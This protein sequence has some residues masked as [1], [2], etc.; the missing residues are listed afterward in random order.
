VGSTLT[1]TH[2]SWTSAT[3]VTYQ[4]Q[5]QRC[6]LVCTDIPS[7]T[8]DTYVAAADD[9]G[10]SLRV[11][12]TATNTSGSAS[13]Q[14]LNTGV[15]L[16][17]PSLSLNAA[18]V[19]AGGVLTVSGSGFA[20]DTEVAVSIHSDPVSLGSATVGPAGTFALQVTIPASFTGPHV[21]E[22]SGTSALSAP[23]VLSVDVQVDAPAATTTTAP[24]SSS[25]PGGQGGTSSG[26]S[27][28][29]SGQ[30]GS[31]GSSSQGGASLPYTGAASFPLAA[32]GLVLLA[33]GLALALWSRRLWFKGW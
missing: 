25:P 30:P 23:L 12:V 9:V 5:W 1:A 27:S 24:G 26:G 3:P 7:A 14:S 8:A 19:T 6:E 18:T 11:V 2:G 33:A 17:G 16:I 28:N 20:P 15:V 29:S 10:S 22:A 13:S 4:V 31:S 32:G 21:I